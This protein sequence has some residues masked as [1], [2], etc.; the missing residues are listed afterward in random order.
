MEWT[1][2]DELVEMAVF[3]A[4]AR[5]PII[6]NDPGLVARFQLAV[7]FYKFC[8]QNPVFLFRAIMEEWPE[9]TMKLH[10]KLFPRHKGKVKL[11]L[12]WGSC[13]ECKSRGIVGYK[14]EDCKL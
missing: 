5:G 7:M 9:E 11:S 2:A 14:C 12:D 8:C 10:M 1:A 6:T 3:A 13:P 4:Q